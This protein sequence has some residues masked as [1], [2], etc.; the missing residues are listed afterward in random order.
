M[1]RVLEHGKAST[2]NRHRC[3]CDEC[4]TAAT[5]YRRAQR[6]KHP[7]QKRRQEL[8]TDARHEAERA[9]VLN[10]PTEFARLLHAARL[11]RGLPTTDPDAALTDR[12]LFE[13]TPPLGQMEGEVALMRVDARKSA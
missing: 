2:Y 13:S 10:H 11:A 7:H 3:R 8:K 1:S 6:E 9:L 4:R 5:A 12:L